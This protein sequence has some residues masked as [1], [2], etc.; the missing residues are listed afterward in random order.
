[1]LNTDDSADP[2]DNTESPSSSSS[3]LPSSTSPQDEPTQQQQQPLSP[4]SAHHRHHRPHS[5]S[6]PPE[7]PIT[8]QI[9]AAEDIWNGGSDFRSATTL[10]KDTIQDSWADFKR[11]TET[12]LQQSRFSPMSG[13]AFRKG[14]LEGV[15]AASEWSERN[16]EILRAMAEAFD[17][18]VSDQ[19][20]LTERLG[21]LAFS[22]LEV[23][24]ACN[25]P[26]QTGPHQMRPIDIA[27]LRAKALTTPPRMDWNYFVLVY[28]LCSVFVDRCEVKWAEEKKG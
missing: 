18:A 9:Q 16:S 22:T 5:P 21:H 7:D 4:R 11:A 1:M 15:K 25:I 20:M 6:L 8:A 12:Y 19:L 3:S 26:I 23:C 17:D 13:D 10:Y 24:R 27:R 28:L 2:S 14:G